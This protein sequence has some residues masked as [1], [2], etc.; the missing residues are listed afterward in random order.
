MFRFILLVGLTAFPLLLMAGCGSCGTCGGCGGC[1]L[2]GDYNLCDSCSRYSG[3]PSTYDDR[4]PYDDG[5]PYYTDPYGDYN[6][7]MGS[8]RHAYVYSPITPGNGSGTPLGGNPPAPGYSAP[9]GVC[10]PDYNTEA[11]PPYK[12]NYQRRC[13][14]N[15]YVQWLL[16]GDCEYLW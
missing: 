9:G 14:M 10:R 4:S 3:I 13:P 12:C 2:C 6:P 11:P 16:S 1:S 8:T 15:P 5:S 7:I